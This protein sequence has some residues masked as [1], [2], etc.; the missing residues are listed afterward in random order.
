MLYRHRQFLLLLSF[1]ESEV[2]GVDSVAMK[3]VS[4]WGD[5]MIIAPFAFSQVGGAGLREGN[6]ICELF[7]R[8]A[9]YS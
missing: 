7:F 5:M 9:S 1:S 4:F 2:N 8:F 6:S 3:A